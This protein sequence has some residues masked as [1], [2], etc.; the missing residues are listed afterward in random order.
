MKE[1]TNAKRKN[2]AFEPYAVASL[3]T[4]TG[5]TQADDHSEAWASWE[6]Q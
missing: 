6:A 3:S 5:I 1:L 2:A 4:P